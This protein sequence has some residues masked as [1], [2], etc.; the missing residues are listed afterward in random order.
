MWSVIIYTFV[1]WRHTPTVR[2]GGAHPHTGG[3][4]NSWARLWAFWCLGTTLVRTTHAA[5]GNAWAGGAG[6]AR[7]FGRSKT[8]DGQ[9][10]TDVVS[11]EAHH[12]PSESLTIEAW[13]MP[14]DPF[15]NEHAIFSFAAYNSRGYHSDGACCCISK[16]QTLTL[17]P[18]P[19]AM[20][21]ILYPVPCTLNPVPAAHSPPRCTQ[22]SLPAT[23]A[24]P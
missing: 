16:H 10:N 4:A 7:R 11:S 8:S 20:P 23:L 21:T 6:Y 2:G 24:V 3:M 17:P 19:P 22:N 12:L 15:Q 14:T 18:L 5:T 13:V 1:H 9:T